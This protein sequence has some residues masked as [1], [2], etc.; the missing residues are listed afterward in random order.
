M[1]CAEPEH[2][3]QQ[4]NYFATFEQVRFFT[5]SDVIL[6]MVVGGDAGLHFVAVDS[7]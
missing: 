6:K 2:V 7:L 4:Q 1:K 5:F 3:M